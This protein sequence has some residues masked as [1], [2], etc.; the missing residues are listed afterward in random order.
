MAERRM[1]ANTI[2]DS[3][4]FVQMPLAAQALYF[5]LNQRA[6]DEGFVNKPQGIMRQIGC[7]GDHAMKVLVERKFVIAFDSGVVVIK[8]WKINNYIQK[9]RFHETKYK[10]E[11][12]QLE[13]DEN[14]SYRCKREPCIQPGH[15]MDTE[16]RGGK[17]RQ[18]KS[19]S[20]RGDLAPYGVRKN[21]MLSEIE[22]ETV[23]GKYQAPKG[24]IDKISLYLANAPRQYEDHY[25]L[26]EK[27]ATEDNWARKKAEE[28]VTPAEPINPISDEERQSLME[29]C[30]GY[31]NG[32]GE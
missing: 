2:V 5:H 14:G 26:L 27:I 3:D 23:M 6:D 17:V 8:H 15:R 24:H 4:A 9:D 12:E 25:A 18:G 1:I 28:V 21:V 7:R 30:K 13:T 19:K 32:G 10:G 31:L 29:R 16:V 20:E 11:R 22:Y